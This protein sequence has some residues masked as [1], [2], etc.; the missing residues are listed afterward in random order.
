MLLLWSLWSLTKEGVSVEPHHSVLCNWEGV[1][2]V[3]FFDDDGLYVFFDEDLFC[4]ADASDEEAFVL[5]GFFSERL[6]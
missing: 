4:S 3:G 2:E 5:D 1:F 6:D